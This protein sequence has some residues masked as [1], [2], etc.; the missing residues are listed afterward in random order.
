MKFKSIALFLLVFALIGNAFADESGEAKI[1]P[2]LQGKKLSFHEK[3]WFMGEKPIEFEVA[4]NAMKSNEE[5]ASA[6]ST[7]MGFYYPG[8]VL[9]YAGGGV[10][11][12]GV[13]TWIWGS[14]TDL[15][16]YLTIG[17]G[18]AIGISLLLT[19]IADSYMHDAIDL[20]NKG[21][22]IAETSLRLKLV[23][24]EQGGIAVALAF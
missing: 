20:Y 9:A 19:K 16:M 11:G 17:G 21:I 12:Y 18:C 22:G 7:A 13:V 8:M 24:T 1:S 4:R 15:G 23:P 2:S 6:Y 5:S 3:H 14:N 10:F